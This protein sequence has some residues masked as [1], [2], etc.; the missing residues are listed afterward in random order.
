MM[1][2]SAILEGLKTKKARRAA[3]EGSEIRKALIDLRNL[4]GKSTS[5]FESPTRR[6]LMSKIYKVPTTQIVERTID[7]SLDNL[8]IMAHTS[9]ARYIG[10]RLDGVPHG[11]GTC[12][13]PDGDMY[14]GDWFGGLPHGE[15]IY[16]WA[17][18]VAYIGTWRNGIRHGRGGYIID[19]ETYLCVFD[20]DRLISLD[21]EIIER[22]LFKK[23]A[24]KA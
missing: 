5:T 9:G 13:T 23:K 16:F 4:K 15:G 6:Q 20:N 18:G 8:N 19:D 22:V 14:N 12:V 11:Y 10:E 17:D 2:R 21:G 7:V 24:L 1:T 3:N